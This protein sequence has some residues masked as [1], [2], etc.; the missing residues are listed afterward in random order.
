MKKDYY[1]ILGVQKNASKDEI[2]KAFRSLA[3]KHHPDKKGGDEAKFKEANEAYSVLSDDN[4]RKQYD[5]YGHAFA[6]ASGPGGAGYGP[7]GGGFNGGQGFEGFDFSGFNNMN[8]Q[9]FEGFDLGDIFGEFF[10]GRS[11]GSRRTARG[12]DISIDLELSFEESI[13]GVEKNISITKTS[14][15]GECKGSGARPGTEMKTCDTCGGK[16]KIRETKRS[17][18]GSFVTTR[19]CEVCKGT[20]KI[21]KEKCLTCHGVGTTRKHHEIN[22][23]IPAGIED[24]EMVRLSGMGEA[25][26]G[27]ASGDLY[28]KIHVKKHP[29]FVKEGHDLLTAL[30]IKL[31]T[32]LLGGEYALKTLDGEIKL[33]IP[34]G[35]S[36]GEILRVHGK[37][38][39]S[40]RGKRGD[41]LVKINLKLPGRLSRTA[42]KL[43]EELKKEGL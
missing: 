37:G 12:R 21:P 29:I 8:G 34:A 43:V 2:K 22:V 41:I 38:V 36:H 9:G 40:E 11:S 3:H 24:G 16:G 23:K 1:E 17:F 35:I 7:F 20:G 31:S 10:G 28:V 42:E 26:A 6:G 18:I 33:K 5:A 13:F 25:V 14:L 27:G 4:K 15:C 19:E 32:A 39:P 30:D